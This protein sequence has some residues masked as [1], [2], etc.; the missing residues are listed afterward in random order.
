MKPPVEL[1]LQVFLVAFT[2]PTDACAEQREAAAAAVTALA[3]MVRLRFEG[4]RPL[5]FT[6]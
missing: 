3:G 5:Q 2:S 6:G 1:C 4:E